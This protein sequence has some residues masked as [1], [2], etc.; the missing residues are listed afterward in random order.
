MHFVGRLVYMCSA[1]LASRYCTTRCLSPQFSTSTILLRAS[2]ILLRV[3]FTKER[4]QFQAATKFAN[5]LLPKYRDKERRARRYLSSII[6]WRPWQNFAN[7]NVTRQQDPGDGEVSEVRVTANAATCIAELH[8]V[9][10]KCAQ[11]NQIISAGFTIRRWGGDAF[12]T[13]CN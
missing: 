13:F 9:R 5:E 2:Y 7:K 6:K 11:V 1:R 10:L 3:P 12:P 4:P 8:I